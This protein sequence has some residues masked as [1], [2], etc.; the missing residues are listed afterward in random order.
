MVNGSE[1]MMVDPDGAA[2][3]EGSPARCLDRHQHSCLPLRYV[4]S[5][6]RMRPCPPLVFEMSIMSARAYKP[7]IG[8]GDPLVAMS[9]P[10]LANRLTNRCVRPL[11]LMFAPSE[12]PR[13]PE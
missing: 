3:S 13:R 8:V 10:R 9:G 1:E 6:L 7:P 12:I 11:G 2:F 4:R 5:R